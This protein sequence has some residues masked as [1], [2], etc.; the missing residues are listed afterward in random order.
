LSAFAHVRKEAK[1]K[2]HW[3]VDDVLALGPCYTE[4]Q[5]RN[6]FGDCKTLT[7]REMLML[8]RVPVKD[9]LWLAWRVLTTEERREA[10]DRII[11][12][13]VRRCALPYEAT[14]SWAERWLSGADRS[15]GAA[16]A[17][18]ETVTVTR[19]VAAAKAAAA[20]AWAAWT[21]T[22]LPTWAPETA[23]EEAAKQAAAAAACVRAKTTTKAA[24]GAFKG[25]WE[26]RRIE[27]LQQLADVLA[28]LT[29]EEEAP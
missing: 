9:R 2:T 10:L 15:R 29:S 21:S 7:P 14:S 24:P 6:G 4:Q 5:V 11:T 25:S 22:T 16:K 3:T 19:T 23:A 13:A 8:S 27:E 20:A 12:R 17:A 26:A 18:A 1:M 28:S